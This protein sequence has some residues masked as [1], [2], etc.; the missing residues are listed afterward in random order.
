MFPKHQ[1]IINKVMEVGMVI[2]SQVC[3]THGLTDLM[4]KQAELNLGIICVFQD[5]ISLIN[6]PRN[7]V[8]VIFEICL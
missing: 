2:H 8:L 3:D 6:S 4:A 1:S 7:F 5:T